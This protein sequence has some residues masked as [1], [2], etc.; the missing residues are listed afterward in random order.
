ML[1]KSMTFFEAS[2]F[3]IK[4]MVLLL[5]SNPEEEDLPPIKITVP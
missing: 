4:V 2:N 1:L 3:K 5:C